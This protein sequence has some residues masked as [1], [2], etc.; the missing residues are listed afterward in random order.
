MLLLVGVKPRFYVLIHVGKLLAGASSIVVS[1]LETSNKC[2][3]RYS[4]SEVVLI[5]TN[6][7][8]FPI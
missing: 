1:K 2:P 5:R 7:V 4:E 6:H 3:G 8:P